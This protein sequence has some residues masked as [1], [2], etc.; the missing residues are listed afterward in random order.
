M[1]TRP[2]AQ[3]AG[4]P[5][6]N[7]RAI[8]E[9]HHVNWERYND[10][11]A[12][13]HSGRPEDALAGFQGLLAAADTPEDR[14]TALLG[15][16]ACLRALG[17]RREARETLSE[18][19]READEKSPLRAWALFSDACLLMDDADWR[20]AL[21]KLDDLS[22]AFADL[23]GQP[24]NEDILGD[25]QRKRGIA[26]CRLHRAAE[27]IGLLERAASRMEEKQT[28]LHCLGRCCY[29]LR[30]F[31]DAGRY[32]QEALSLGLPANHESDAH[33]TLGLSYR[34]RGQNARAIEQFRWCL[35][36]DRNGA[37]PRRYLLTA[38]VEACKALGQDGEAARYSEM[39]RKA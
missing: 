3:P 12:L 13:E 5:S 19:Y 35:D 17:R 39:L 23:L 21:D 14:S 24:G 25:V 26:L 10:L 15:I 8:T 6:P 38:L 32:L 18:I 4:R 36:K 30:R 28:V 7:G 34:W 22:S 31:E 27:A 33:Y 37:V 9:R 11:Q 29:E 16:G 2:E 1:L 20:S